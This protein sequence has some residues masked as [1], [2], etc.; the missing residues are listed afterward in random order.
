M[1]RVRILKTA[2]RDLARLD[3]S[4]ARRIVERV[5]WLA[6][7]IENVRLEGLRGELA[8]LYKFRVG[9]YRVIYELIHE[10]QLLI[11]HAIGHRKEIYKNTQI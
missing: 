4:V 2:V 8:G 3:K 6:A 11:I 9:S 5:N 1:Y 10:E 7:N